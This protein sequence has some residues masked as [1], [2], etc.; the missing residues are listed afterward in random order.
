M[1]AS[2]NELFYV[3]PRDVGDNSAIITFEIKDVVQRFVKQPVT[4][5]F[6]TLT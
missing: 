5:T 4:I 1:P 2:K 3:I 6:W